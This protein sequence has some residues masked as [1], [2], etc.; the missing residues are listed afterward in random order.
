MR[1]RWAGVDNSI[2]AEM[3]WK[4]VNDVS[5]EKICRSTIWSAFEPGTVNLQVD[6]IEPKKE[7]P[8]E[9]TDNDKLLDDFMSLA[10]FDTPLPILQNSFKLILYLQVLNHKLDKMWNEVQSTLK[11]L[12]NTIFSQDNQRAMA[13][14]TVISLDPSL[15]KL[16]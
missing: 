9:L 10:D 12:S 15:E 3:C 13:D 5:V 11:I 7:D 8:V 1:G 6:P 2:G 14:S 4:L 16:M